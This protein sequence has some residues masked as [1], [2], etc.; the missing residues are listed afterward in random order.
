MKILEVLT[1]LFLVYL[2]FAIVISGIQ[3]WWAQYRGHRGRFL[4]LGVQRLIGDDAIFVR[5]LQHPLIGSLYRDRAARGKPPSYVDPNNF[6]LAFSHVVIRRQSAATMDDAAANPAAT[7]SAPLSYALLRD[8]VSKLAAQRSPVAAAALPIIDQAQGNLDA[9]LKGLAAWYS[10]GMDRVSGWYKGYA[11]RRLL[12]IGFIVACIGNIDT[13]EI[14][15]SLNNSADLRSQ[16]ADMGDTIVR[17]HKIGDVDVSVLATRDLTPEESKAVLKVALDSP[18]IKLP[19][20]YGCLDATSAISMPDRRGATA[21][22]RCASAFEKTVHQWSPSEWL[23]HALGWAL[24][25]LA[26][27]LGAPYWFSALSK[28]VNIRGSGSKP[29]GPAK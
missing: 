6:A 4:R 18:V 27:L 10:G 13:I 26:G 22:S 21:W 1:G 25:A 19:I 9:A 23:L 2:I 17:S 12:V 24:T 7:E 8:A 16:L 20:G 14:Y 29:D 11:Q 15:R 3:E 5:V 28:V